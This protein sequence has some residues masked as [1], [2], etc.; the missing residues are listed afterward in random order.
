MDRARAIRSNLNLP[1]NMWGE[2][3]LTSVYVKNRTVSRFKKGTTPFEAYYGQK[4]DL[5]HMQEL[6]CQAFV[7]KQGNHPKIHERSVECILIRYS[8]NSKAY[9][10]YHHGTRRI[11]T[12]HDMT[13]IESQDSVPHARTG[14]CT[15]CHTGEGETNLDDPS[16]EEDQ[17]DSPESNADDEDDPDTSRHHPASRCHPNTSGCNQGV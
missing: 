17:L 12:S 9:W 3:M 4:P 7:L 1:A 11:H 13:F 8:T 6:G 14:L 10:C 15:R 5:T 2:C 16:E